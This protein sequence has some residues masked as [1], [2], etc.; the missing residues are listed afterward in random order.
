[1]ELA[2]KHATAFWKYWYSL[3]PSNIREILPIAPSLLELDKNVVIHYWILVT[4]AICWC[5]QIIAILC[6]I[7]QEQGIFWV[8]LGSVF[9]SYVNLKIILLKSY[10]N[11]TRILWESYK[12]SSD[13]TLRFLHRAW[14]Q[15]FRWSCLTLNM[16]QFLGVYHW[17]CMNLSV[18]SSTFP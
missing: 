2:L 8:P 5:N 12:F 7:I 3:T 9:V 15:K 6:T 11:L 4:I 17:S 13:W 10:D 16:I 14:D 18:K 1:M